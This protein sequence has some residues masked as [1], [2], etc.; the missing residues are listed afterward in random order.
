MDT[1]PK[2]ISDWRELSA[3]TPDLAAQT[4]TDS[5]KSYDS[6]TLKRV[7][8]ALPNFDTL[9]DA[10]ERAAHSSSGAL[11]GVPFMLK[12][13]FDYPGFPTTASSSFLPELRPTPK[14]ESALSQRFRKQ[15][16]VFTGK[17]HLNEFAYGLSGENLHFGDCP[18]PVFPNRLS[19]GSSSGS[20][21][22]VKSGI[23]PIATGTDTGGSIR[24]PAA[25]CGLYGIR[26]APNDW[27]TDGC[28]PLAPSFDTAGWFCN[29]ATDMAEA[30][31]CLVSPPKSDKKELRGISLIDAFNSIKPDHRSALATT[32][33]QLDAR[34]NPEATKDYLQAT[35]NV[36][37]NYS[38]LQSRE[39]LE[40]HKDWIDSHKTSYDP[41]VWQRIERA[42]HWSAE[43]IET[44]YATEAAVKS[45]FEN[46]FSSYDYIVMPATQSPA[47]TAQ[48][49]T[50]AFRS[51]LLSYTAP[52]SLARC[53]VLTVPIHLP[54]GES[55]GLQIMY[56]DSNSD[57]PIRLLDQ[58]EA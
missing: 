5:L 38:V 25:W 8:A 42:R 43:Q 12:D 11:A 7:F 40:V 14:T 44:A 22:A 19:G 32:I 54:S 26:F 56:R 29:S 31:Q 46:C 20:A 27:S 13:L 17:T 47:I 6:R 3:R 2:A 41:V 39:A 58:K 52:G 24:V 4:L 57:L 9:E 1:Q 10:F 48:Q 53:P 36:A 18:H 33:S 35:R 55:L 30:I 16:G 51:E 28:V 50:E 49:H 23:V 45:F 15:G 37:F 21:W 34:S